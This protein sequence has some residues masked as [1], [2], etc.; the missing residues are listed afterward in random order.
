MKKKPKELDDCMNERDKTHKNPSLI[1]LHALILFN[2]VRALFFRT[3]VR[4]FHSET[5]IYAAQQFGIEKKEYL[6]E[7]GWEWSTD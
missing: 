7:Q 4:W 2:L 5:S 6:N 3:R 1:Q